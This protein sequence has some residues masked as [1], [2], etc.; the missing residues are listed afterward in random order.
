MK[1]LT[2]IAIVLLPAAAVLIASC[3]GDS[4]TSGQ[5]QASAAGGIPAAE[6]SAPI[7]AVSSPTQSPGPIAQADA[8]GVYAPP[9]QLTGEPE[10]AVGTKPNSWFEATDMDMG[11]FYMNEAAHGTFRFKN[12]TDQPRRFTDLRQSCHCT[13]SRFLV[14]DEEYFMESTADGPNVLF[15]LVDRNGVMNP[16]RVDF[17]DIGPGEEGVIEVDMEMVNTR[18]SRMATIGFAI[19][20]PELPAVMLRF[21]A[22]GAVFFNVTPEEV[23]LNKMVWNETREFE[24]QVTSPVLGDFEIT[25]VNT[26]PPG[27]KVSW[28]K[29]MRGGQ[30]MFTIKG[31][32]GPLE[33]GAGRGGRL[34]FHVDQRG[35]TFTVPVIAF[36]EGPLTLAPGG[37]LALGR[38]A[39]DTAVSK[40]VTI[41]AAGDYD[42]QV[43]GLEGKD[44]SFD[45]KF[46]NLSSVKNDAG[47]IEVTVEVSA[48][49]PAGTVVRGEVVIHLNH[50]AARSQTI[51]FNGFVR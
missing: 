26:P 15:K 11:T 18:G 25:R 28:E 8:A 3:G 24:V 36:I 20:D 47:A 16:E 4:A 2:P 50:P 27:M 51:L 43:E 23:N 1:F 49:V 21:Y 35:L 17:I 12:P 13:K 19:D 34:E 44:L 48:G 7:P 45:K 39:K 38:I 37:F 40:T 32:Y 14:G 6:V 9:L 22:L 10:T 41:A 29:S 30:T 5:A 42:L 46:L 33:A 31:T